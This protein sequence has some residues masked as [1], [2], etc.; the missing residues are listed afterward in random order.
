MEEW[1][2]KQDD[3][4]NFVQIIVSWFI[5][6]ILKKKIHFSQSWIHGQIHVN[7]KL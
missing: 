2:D 4:L 7:C 3:I 5:E 6:C 1:K